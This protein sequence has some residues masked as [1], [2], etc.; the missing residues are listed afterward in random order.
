M[1]VRS[2]A[3]E[4]TMQ[5][6]LPVVNVLSVL[7]T[8]TTNIEAKPVKDVWGPSRLWWPWLI[9]AALLLALIGLAYWWYRR[10]RREAAV[11]MPAQPMVDPRERALQELRR[12]RELRLVE[13]Q[14]F[15]QHYILLSEVLR[16]FAAA[17]EA[18]WSTDLTTDELAPRVKRRSDAA[19]LIRI[20]RNADTVK[21]AKRVPPATEARTDLD[22]AEE[23]VRTFNRPVATAEAA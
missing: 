22:A 9:A 3:R 16:S 18:E 19:P 21:F 6:K 23:W 12:L 13:Q 1:I 8:D 11:A 20:L 2:D 17:S 15:K 14:Q 7:P 4:R 10:R 5:V